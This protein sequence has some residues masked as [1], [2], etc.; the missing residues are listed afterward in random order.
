MG[1]LNYLET[2]PPEAAFDK[3]KTDFKGTTMNG[4]LP[5]ESLPERLRSG[6]SDEGYTRCQVHAKYMRSYDPPPSRALAQRRAA[7]ARRP[8]SRVARGPLTA[9]VV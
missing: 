2:A 5:V 4:V 7:G 3:A 1:K 8:C 9:G 6:E